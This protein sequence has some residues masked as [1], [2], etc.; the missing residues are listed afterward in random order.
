MFRGEA[1]VIEE[2]I[3]DIIRSPL[4][5]EKSTMASQYGWYSFK[6]SEDASKPQIKKA[7]QKLFNVTVETVNTLNTKGKVKK[8]K[9]ILG[10]R[11]GFKKALVKLKEGDSIDTTGEIK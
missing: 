9:G 8:F 10:K 5:T 11:K 1:T 3:Y 6:V 7:V 4:S 2:R